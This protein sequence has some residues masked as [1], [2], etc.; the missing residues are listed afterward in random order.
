[1]KSTIITLLC[2]LVFTYISMGVINLRA[3]KKETTFIKKA[4]A[5][6]PRERKKQIYC[7]A[8]LVYMIIL[9]VTITKVYTGNCCDY[10]KTV[11]IAS[12]MW[13]M[14]QIDYRFLRIPNKLILLGLI[15]RGIILIFEIIFYSEG[16]IYT[17]LFEIIAAFAIGII[18][19]ISSV[20]VKNGVGMGDV[21]F[22][23]LTG[24]FIGAY[25]LISAAIIIMFIAL[26]I[27]IYKLAV[28][29]EGKKAEFAFGPSI[30]IG[31]LI[32][33]IMFGN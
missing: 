26:C 23:M 4:F 24:L 19:I 17:V 21:K 30:A 13:P 8:M 2:S 20:I 28:K 27:S 9:P 3:V 25:R 15:Y 5:A 32:S 1:M 11:A 7:I 18:L 31:S 14:A 10:I 22:L 12:L 33:F 6:F 16:L 29:K